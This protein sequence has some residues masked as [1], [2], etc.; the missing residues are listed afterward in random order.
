MSPVAGADAG[1]LVSTDL[2]VG[3]M[4]CAACVGRVEKR[5]ARIDGVSA[6]VNLATG[7]ARVLHPAAVPVAE[8]VAAVER[9]GYTAE[10]APEG[11]ASECRTRSRRSGGGCW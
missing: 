10:P 8:L 1:A 2:A 4:T 6:G 11:W 9:A 5:L 3:G 7:R